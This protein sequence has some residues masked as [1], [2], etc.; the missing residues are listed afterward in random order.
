MQDKFI[1]AS[2]P[3]IQMAET[4]AAQIEARS[5]QAATQRRFWRLVLQDRQGRSRLAAVPVKANALLPDMV[6]ET[7]RVSVPGY[8]NPL[9]RVLLRPRAHIVTL[10]EVRSLSQFRASFV[11]SS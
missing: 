7:N 9:A 8:P 1:Q 5:R 6:H 3:T 10:A 4:D 2:I 11:Q